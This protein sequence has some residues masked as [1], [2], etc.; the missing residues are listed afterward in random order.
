M[1]RKGFAGVRAVFEPQEDPLGLVKMREGDFKGKTA[2]A[3][4]YGTNVPPVVLPWGIGLLSAV[5]HFSY[6]IRSF[7]RAFFSMRDT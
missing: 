3:M 4:E 6:S 7:S 2:T 5:Q 1:N